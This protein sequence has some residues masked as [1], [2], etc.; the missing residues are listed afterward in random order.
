MSSLWQD[1][2]PE[3]GDPD[4]EVEKVEDC[5]GDEESGEGEVPVDLLAA[6]AVVHLA[7]DQRHAL[8][9]RQTHD[10][11][12]VAEASWWEREREREIEQGNG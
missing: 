7:R 3:Y 5:E 2:Q 12:Y 8:V 10:R 9:H 6:S 1:R 11:E 4:K